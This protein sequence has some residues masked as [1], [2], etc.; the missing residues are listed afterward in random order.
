MVSSITLDIIKSVVN[1]PEFI[2]EYISLKKQGS[3]LTACC[4][5]H[6]EKTPSF[7]VNDSYFKCFGCG[8]AGDVFSFLTKY[9]R[10]SFT[11]AV[12]TIAEKYHID[13]E[14]ESGWTPQA[15]EERKGKE[16]RAKEVLEFVQEA[17]KKALWEN[18]HALSYLDERGISSE[19]ALQWQMGFAPMDFQF[20]SSEIVKNGW[21]D[22]A[23][24]L[25]VIRMNKSRY[26]DFFV[27]RLMMPIH[28]RHGVLVGWSGRSLPEEDEPGDVATKTQK[29]IAKYLNSADS[30]LFKKGEVLFG[31]HLAMDEMRNRN[32][33]YKVEGNLDVVLMHQAGIANTVA[34]LGTALTDDHVRILRN[35]HA[36][37]ILIND[38]DAAGEKATMKQI[39]QLIAADINCHVVELPAGLDPADIINNKKTA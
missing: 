14:L 36:D 1:L 13:V 10:M 3:K 30:F 39:D 31:Y 8:V 28:D 20:V 7:V 19:S 5:F 17:Y 9:L 2:G 4:P 25:G 26:Y 12:E 27:N 38:S 33:L 15:Y 22:I 6:G 29:K 21:T 23:L 35:S 11:E 18:E 24:E 32:E 37:I 16:A 34:A